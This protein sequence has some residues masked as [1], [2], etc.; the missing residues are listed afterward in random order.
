MSSNAGLLA[1]RGHGRRRG[2]RRGDGAFGIGLANDRR[3]A[4]DKLDRPGL[5]RAA[6]Q[7]EFGKDFQ[8]RSPGVAVPMFHER[9]QSRKP[10]P[11]AFG[12]V[13]QLAGPLGR[14]AACGIERILMPGVPRLVAAAVVPVG[15][16]AQHRQHR[17]PVALGGVED[18]SRVEHAR[19]DLARLLGVG[20]L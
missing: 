17:Q 19:V 15:P 9:M 20:G 7:V 3:W 14:P 1:V 11:A 6:D 13:E 8:R 5:G 18:V 2:L 12:I 4:L 10:K 16:D